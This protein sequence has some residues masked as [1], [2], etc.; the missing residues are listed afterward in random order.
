MTR[1]VPAPALLFLSAMSL[2]AQCTLEIGTV[3]D[4]K[5]VWVDLTHNH[6]LVRNDVICSDS[7]VQRVNDTDASPTDFLKLASRNDSKQTVR[8]EC[9]SLLGC[10]KALDL[11]A[12]VNEEQRRLKG[13]GFLESFASW[14]NSGQHRSHTL[15]RSLPPPGT[16]VLRT[17]VIYAGKPI[18]A[19][20]VF[21]AEAPAGKYQFDLCAEPTDTACGNTLPSPKG[22]SWQPGTTANL[23]FAAPTAGVYI[24]YRLKEDDI[25]LR[26]D[27]RVLVIAVD[28]SN[29]DRVKEARDKIA[30]AAL[31]VSPNDAGQVAAF[32]EYVRSVAERLTKR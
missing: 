12:L 6:R 8:F 13:S 28:P 15:S 21:S 14:R 11:S 29:A 10:G 2:A 9:R 26:T 19:V 32:E 1:I 25:E 23:P 3:A 27:D 24:L 31:S 16:S 4:F 18:P 22:F 30:I 17:A 5:G 20:E 7:K